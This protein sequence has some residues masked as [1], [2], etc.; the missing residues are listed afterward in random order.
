[1]KHINSLGLFLVICISANSQQ[2][3]IINE[4]LSS[5]QISA[6][7]TDSVKTAMKINFPIYRVY[8]YIDKSGQHYCVLTESRDEIKGKDTLHYKIKALNCKLVDGKLSKA[9]ELNDN[10]IKSAQEENSIWFWT[11]F[12]EFK[13]YDKDGLVEPVITYGTAAMNGTDDGRIKILIYYKGQKIAIRHQNGIL[14]F[15]RETQV[16]NAFYTLPET[17]QSAVKQKMELMVKNDVAIFP[18]GWQLAMKN[19]KLVFNERK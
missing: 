10:I 6:L 5:R 11:K 14:D 9:W 8:Q 17:L 18:H 15:E 3:S 13:D 7:L 12:T 1:M 16:D 4:I 2:S 19:K